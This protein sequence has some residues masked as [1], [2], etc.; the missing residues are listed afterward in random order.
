[1]ADKEGE[2]TCALSNVGG[3]VFRKTPGAQVTVV[4]CRKLYGWNP[5]KVGFR[6]NF[7][8]FCCALLACHVGR[9][10]SPSVSE[11]GEKTDL[12]NFSQ[13]CKTK[14]NKLS[15]NAIKLINAEVKLSHRPRTWRIQS[16]YGAVP[17][18]CTIVMG[19]SRYHRRRVHWYRYS[20]QST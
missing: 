17:V 14:T 3:G 8:F 1:M 7:L 15:N 9:G 18:R 2:S 11:V 4:F 13:K 12:P 20:T 16:I 10:R 6:F 5:K 19:V